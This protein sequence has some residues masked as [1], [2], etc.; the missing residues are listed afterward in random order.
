METD[1][2][3]AIFCWIFEY[4][5]ITSDVINSFDCILEKVPQQNVQLLF[6]KAKTCLL[7][8]GK[9]QKQV[10]VQWIMIGLLIIFFVNFKEQ[11]K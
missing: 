9:R 7:F 5:V 3:S 1:P 2:F 4:S 10:A 8:I 6:V 11:N